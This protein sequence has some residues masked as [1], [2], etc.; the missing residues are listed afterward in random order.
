MTEKGKIDAI[1]SESKE[2]QKAKGEYS[3]T[4]VYSDVK[5][6]EEDTGIEIPTDEAVEEAKEWVDNQNQ[7]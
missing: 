5:E 1:I 2:K 3:G 7:M 6:R 4:D